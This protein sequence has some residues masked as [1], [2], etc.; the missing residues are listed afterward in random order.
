MKAAL[1]GS[2]RS[3]GDLCLRPFGLSTDNFALSQTPEGGY[4]I[5]FKNP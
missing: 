2:L 3:L 1:V 4:N 5:G